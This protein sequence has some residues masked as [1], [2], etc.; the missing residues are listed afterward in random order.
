MTFLTSKDKKFLATGRFK[1][2]AVIEEMILSAM[3]NTA[4]I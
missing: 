4:L 1:F 3:N 2:A